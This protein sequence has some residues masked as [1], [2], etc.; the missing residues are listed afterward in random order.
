MSYK[1]TIL[2]DYPIAYYPLDELSGTT[3]LDY[4]GCENDGSYTGSIELN[5]LPL[6]VG[7]NRATKIT[8]TSSLSYPIS[9]DY[10][11]VSTTSRFGTSKSS[12]NDFSIEFWFYPS[13]STSNETPL[14]G[15]STN[16]IGVFYQK[17]NI[18]FQI[19]T[20]ILEYTLPSLNKSFHIVATYSINS[21]AIYV[22]GSLVTLRDLSDFKFTNSAVDLASGPT[23]S[24]DTF[25]INSVAVYRYAL[26]LDQIKYHFGQG[27]SLPAIHI[28]DPLSGEL[29]EMYDNELSRLYKFEYPKNRNWESI[30]T[31]GLTYDATLNCLEITQTDS[32]ASSTVVVEEFISI[33]KT[34]TFDSSKIEWDGEN[35]ISIEASTDGST[36]NACVNGQQIP[37]YTLNSFASTGKL[38]LRIT[39]TSTDTSRYIPRLFNLS[40]SF[41]N[42]QTK[43]AS[44]GYGYFSTLEEDAGI[45]DY[46]VT[47]GKAP[48]NILSRNSRNGIRTVV[49]SGFEITTDKE[50]NTIEFFYTPTAITDSGL[51]STTS[52]N[53]YTAS[54]IYWHNS[55]TMSKTNI[56]AIYVNGV[57]KSSETD[58]S[59]IFKANQLHHVVVVFGSA[60]SGDIRFN[61][62]VYG[63]VSALYQYIAF[64]PTAFDSNQATANYNLYT[65]KQYSTITDSSTVNL[66]E[67]GVDSYN[68]DWLVV[69]NI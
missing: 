42:N 13:F 37:G 35:G 45:S 32:A 58:V 50:I 60:V 68:N 59:N 52:T 57:N 16:N 67:D 63:S 39:F 48:Y 22:D 10:T 53:G 47:L 31:T 55:G 62:S 14:V 2:Y 46:R 24:S 17:G 7:C 15:D 11:A 61:Y 33:P 34:A 1:S 49:D 23:S 30:V 20:E 66:T 3:A 9:N 5:L 26:S 43:Y 19:D 56:S 64:Y 28:A 54:N 41:Y 69:Q 21:A 51:L 44:N 12:D 8:S 36:Y 25:L 6:V 18:I 27:Q 40:I 38:F 29:Y 65:K 4:S